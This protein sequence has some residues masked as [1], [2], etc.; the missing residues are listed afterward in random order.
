MVEAILDSYSI[1]VHKRWTDRGQTP[2]IVMMRVGIA[3]LQGA[4]HEH[5]QAIKQASMEM[6][7]EVEVVELRKSEQVDSSIDGLILPG[8]ESTTMRIASL[9]E[10]LLEGLFDWMTQYPDRPV[11]GTCAGAILLAQPTQGR[12]RFINLDIA[13]NAWGRQKFSFEAGVEVTLETPE[14]S[15]KVEIELT[16][17]KFNH[18]PL[19]MGND[20]INSESEQFPGVFIRA[21]R[22]IQDSIKCQPV[23][24]LSQEVV[25]VLQGEKLALTFHPELTGDRRFH[26]WLIGRIMDSKQ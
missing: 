9:S 23:A 25:G 1:N 5:Y 6:Q 2:R 4:R 17:D 24:H 22:F 19:P 3:M 12:E 26:R 16:R 15:T 8:G 10:S 7:Q 11:L 14:Q 20:A 21:P 18:K 13:R